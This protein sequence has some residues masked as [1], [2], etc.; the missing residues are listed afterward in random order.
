MQR[1]D[2]CHAG[3]CRQAP[4]IILSTSLVH[5]NNLSHDQRRSLTYALHPQPRTQDASE[6]ETSS[7][8]SKIMLSGDRPHRHL[9][10]TSTPEYQLQR[11]LLLG[12]KL[13]RDCLAPG[14]ANRPAKTHSMF[15]SHWTTFP[16]LGVA[17]GGRRPRAAQITTNRFRYGW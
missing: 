2:L 1:Q 6:L 12:A 7:S 17:N 3:E 4:P 11:D 15:R 9:N 5:Q 16:H 8:N 13:H 10:A 14:A